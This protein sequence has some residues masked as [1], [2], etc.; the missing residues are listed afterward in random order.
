M[1]APGGEQAGGPALIRRMADGD[2]QAFA[3]FYDRYADLAF[4]LI[5]RILPQPAEA[6][7][8][9]QEVFWQ[10]WVEAASYDRRRGS[11]EAWVLM[12][13]RSRAIDRL[14]AIRRRT[15]TFVAPVDDRTAQAAD[16][17]APSPGTLAEGRTLVQTAL[18]VLPDA[19]RR[20]IE[21]AFYEGLTQVEIAQRLGEPLGT[22][23]TR[24]R[25]GLERLRS[26]FTTLESASR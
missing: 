2:R 18:A 20:V 7:D 19:Q 12:R 26:H 22:V 8:V 14:R 13:A 11:P 15:E 25:A 16:P 6:E 1:T 24:T 4:T 21:L 10:A 9:L 17:T 23:K 3:A 5:R